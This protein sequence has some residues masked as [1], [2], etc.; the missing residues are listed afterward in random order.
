M[1]SKI[2]K[3][4]IF[5]IFCLNFF[6]FS[7]EKIIISGIYNFSPLV[8]Y[9]KGEA[10]GLFVD[11][12]NYIAKKENWKVQYKFGTW[13]ECYENLQNNE[14]QILPCIAY[15][16]ERAKIFDFTNEYLFLDWGLIYRK[17]GSEISNIFELSNKKISALKGSIYTKDLKNILEQFGIN[18]TIIEKSEYKEVLDSISKGETEAGVC[19]NVY[20]SILE[21]DYAVERTEIIFA[22]TKIRFA[23]KK[24]TNSE[25]L[26]TLDKYFASLKHN[27]NSIY[28]EKYREW[29]EIKTTSKIYQWLTWAFIVLLIVS[30]ILSIFVLMLRLIVKQRT[31]ALAEANK[32]L[33]ESEQKFRDTFEQAAV[34]LAHVGI[35][36]K[37]LRVNQKLCDIVGYSKEELLKLTFQ[38]ITYKD[39]LEIDLEFVNKMLQDEIETYTLEKRYIRKDRSIV[40]INLTVS[41]TFDDTNKRYF[42]AVIED[43]SDRKKAEFEIKELNEDLEE[44]VI[45]RT[46]ELEITNEELEATNEE[47]I[48]SNEELI[49]TNDSLEKTLKE[50]KETQEYLI[51]SEKMV[52]LG[53]LIA[54]IAHEINTPLGAIISSNN[55]QNIVLN[56]VINKLSNIFLYIT[57]KQKT[58]FFDL[59][60]KS[61]KIKY[62]F[63]ETNWEYKNILIEKLDSFNIKN[64]MIIADNICDIGIEFDVETYLPLFE[65]KYGE[66]IIQLIYEIVSSKK[67]NKIIEEASNKAKK[68]IDALKIYL[69]K[70]LKENKIEYDVVSGM[71]TVLTLFYNKT[72]HGVEVI[73]NFNTVKKILCYPDKI[74]QVWINIINNALQ[75]MDYKGTLEIN[76]Y[77]KDSHVFVEISNNGQVISNDIKDKIF[78]PFFTTKKQGEGTGLGL[79]IVKRVVDEHN[80]DIEFNSTKEKTTFKVIL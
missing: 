25:L 77:E 46:S 52:A 41:M 34:G 36:G 3:Y 75:A 16:D 79:N 29:L 32:F 45:E 28:Y 66:E 76:I 21:S 4:S 58:I 51:E 71:E 69:Y 50:L 74:N 18:A 67:A 24:D 10:K 78:Q 1:I 14:I 35:D 19:T 13:A 6:A 2:T 9:E 38:D 60:E 68:V 54:G 27:Q 37:W 23:V 47:L 59:L 62:N 56:D 61:L 17:K 26:T 73:R 31:K 80:G 43:I 11:I 65:N 5:F 40:W 48:A 30:L 64:S 42:I 8:F 55:N 39:D 7:E 53:Q 33:K 20:G 49:F 12:L 72:K 57:D 15:S 22:P 70:D 63:S 44:K